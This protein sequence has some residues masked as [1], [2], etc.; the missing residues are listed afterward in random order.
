MPLFEHLHIKGHTAGSSNELSFDVLD[1][2]RK[3]LD[4]PM[5]KRRGFG[6]GGRGRR[7]AQGS[8]GLHASALEEKP[9]A[10]GNVPFTRGT[11][12]VTSS[13]E[14][15]QRSRRGTS[16]RGGLFGG[17]FARGASGSGAPRGARR[18][19]GTV[20]ATLAV[21][22]IICAGILINHQLY[23]DRL[24]F[25]NRLVVLASEISQIDKDLV[26]ADLL[27]RDPL[28]DESREK[29]SSVLGKLPGIESELAGIQEEAAAI[30]AAEPVGYNPAALEEVESAVDARIALI[31]EAAKLLD[32]ANQTNNNI[33]AAETAW[34]AVLDSTELANQ[35]TSL[36]N[37]A[38]S[39]DALVE[40]KD[41]A[42]R[43]LAGYQEASSKLQA[44]QDGLPG[45]N[46]AAHLRFI[47]TK[48][49]ALRYEITVDDALLAQDRTAAQDANLAYNATEDEAA[50]QASL[51]TE[52]PAASVRNLMQERIE[53]L[54]AAYDAVRETVIAADSTLRNRLP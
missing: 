17:G 44:L 34:Q 5:R 27:A 10:E 20:L 9:A 3:G 16:A 32:V 19:V 23:L 7:G 48:I 1:N 14:M 30:R 38:A 29:I 47:D 11:V 41:I 18:V 53:E 43:A 28:G 15:L 35:A 37:E 33:A 2:A 22:A 46:L 31:G 24:D 26:Q 25:T 36:A 39:Q 49:E 12:T 21:I 6:W 13:D 40:S 52:P 4:E 50:S 45:L 51:I 54:E 42:Q 8:R